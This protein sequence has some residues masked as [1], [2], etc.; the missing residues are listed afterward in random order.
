MAGGKPSPLE[1]QLYVDVNKYRSPPPECVDSPLMNPNTNWEY[2]LYTDAGGAS[3]TGWL[4][5][6]EYIAPFPTDTCRISMGT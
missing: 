2:A 6:D 1:S 3:Y 5:L 4:V